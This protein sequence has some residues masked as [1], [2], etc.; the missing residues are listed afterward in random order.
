MLAEELHFGR[1]AE[2]LFI[3]QPPLSRQIKQ[4]EEQLGVKLFRR[5]NKKVELT[6]YGAYLKRESERIFADLVQVERNLSIMRKSGVG[7]ISFG[8]VGA[9]MYSFLPAILKEIKDEYSETYFIL[10]E[11]GNESQI[12]SLRKNL[13]DFGFVRGPLKL[14]DLE[15]IKIES[16]TFS[17][18]LPKS[19]SLAMKENLSPGELRNEP[20]ISFS[21]QC[22]PPMHQSITSIFNKCGVEPVIIHETT[23]INAL[24][25]LVQG[26]FGFSIVPTN[27]RMDQNSDLVFHELTSFEEKTE[28]SLI[29]NSKFANSNILSV[30]DKIVNLSNN[31]CNGS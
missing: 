28:V 7:K 21:K 15:S 26:G 6:E 8:Y 19:H 10:K 2:K 20:F 11:L 5:N 1:A 3:S 14:K 30:I 29:Y 27:I 23:Q 17:I 12:D 25:K 13:I 22:A 16:G 18:V 9:V 31:L 4:L 24:L